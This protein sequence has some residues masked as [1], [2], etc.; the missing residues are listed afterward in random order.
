MVRHL[1]LLTVLPELKLTDPG[2]IL[3]GRNRHAQENTCTG[4]GSG[5]AYGAGGAFDG[6]TLPQAG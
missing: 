2:G 1:T 4:A 5:S 6:F 3:N